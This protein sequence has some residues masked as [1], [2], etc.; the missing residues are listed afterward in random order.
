MNIRT[1][2]PRYAALLTAPTLVAAVLVTSAS[3]QGSEGAVFADRCE[4]DEP[5]VRL[6]DPNYESKVDELA[7]TCTVM[8]TVVYPVVGC[9]GTDTLL[10]CLPNPYLP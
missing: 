6:V 4:P 7:G 2:T 10:G 5:V 9:A 3:V 1:A 8:D